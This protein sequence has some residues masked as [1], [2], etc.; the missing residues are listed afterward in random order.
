[1]AEKETTE[2]GF[3]FGSDLVEAAKDVQETLAGGQDSGDDDR[4]QETPQQ[5]DQGPDDSVSVKTVGG[6]NYV[7]NYDNLGVVDWSN[8]Q[9]D[10]LP[11]DL[12]RIADYAASQPRQRDSGLS[13]IRDL[14]TAQN[15]RIEQLV[16]ER[17]QPV[18]QQEPQQGQGLDT[19][20]ILSE[21]GYYPGQEG[22]A[23]ASAIVRI[24]EA[25]NAKQNADNERTIAQLNQ[26]L[27][28]VTGNV[29]Q[30]SGRVQQQS[31]TSI[32]NEVSAAYQAYGKNEVDAYDD[33]ILKLQGSVNPLTGEVFTV[34]TA[35]EYASG[36]MYQRSQEMQEK[37]R[38]LVNANRNGSRA[39]VSAH[40]AVEAGDT[41]TEAGLE[42]AVGELSSFRS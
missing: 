2:E 16:Q 38:D 33:M 1:M 21:L 7:I 22:H 9:R 3:E 13:E 39:P 14:V 10:S 40:G 24:V 15:Q 28:T 31:R 42:A 4:S 34:T 6:K 8:V 20:T 11:D 35:Y 30:L 17:Q 27:S 37:E 41:L 23:E 19:N 29:E 25:L 18:Q 32:D 26:D 12:K 5:Q 36:K